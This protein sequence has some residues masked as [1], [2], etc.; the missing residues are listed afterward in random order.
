MLVYEEAAVVGSVILSIL[1]S[2]CSCYPFGAGL[3]ACKTLIPG[4]GKEP[5]PPTTL[6][7]QIEPE[8]DTFFPNRLF[9]GKS[10]SFQPLDSFNF[11]KPWKLREGQEQ[12][13]R[14]Y[15]CYTVL[16]GWDF[17]DRAT[18]ESIRLLTQWR[19]LQII[20]KQNTAPS[21]SVLRSGR[22][23]LGQGT[24]KWPVSHIVFYYFTRFNSVGDFEL[25]H[26]Y[27][28]NWKKLV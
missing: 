16:C 24:C 9:K 22:R 7:Y 4:H 26:E 5:Q 15:L 23:F 12:I 3:S 21:R 13:F 14:Y 17:T 19:F 18:N 1:I 25:I 20:R 8:S 11:F 10:S 28:Q 2:L 6:P 27:S